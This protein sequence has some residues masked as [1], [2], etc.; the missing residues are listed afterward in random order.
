MV[1]SKNYCYVPPLQDWRILEETI[2]T[3]PHWKTEE[4]CSSLYF[5]SHIS[6]RKNLSHIFWIPYV[7]VC[8]PVR[9]YFLSASVYVW[10]RYV[11]ASSSFSCSICKQYRSCSRREPLLWIA[12]Q[13]LRSKDITQLSCCDDPTFTY[14]K[15]AECTRHSW[16]IS[17]C[18]CRC[19][20]YIFLLF[21][22]LP[23]FRIRKGNNG[24]SSVLYPPQGRL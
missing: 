6:S 10:P 18:I 23:W 9:T 2:V 7:C 8:V 20:I 11:V 12:R 17:R 13:K 3:S 5:S 19:F 15:R 24:L 22:D 14:L 21:S 16:N 4:S 1:D